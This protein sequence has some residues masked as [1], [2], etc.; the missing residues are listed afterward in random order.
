MAAVDARKLFSLWE[1]YVQ[2]TLY[3]QMST[4]GTQDAY[5]FSVQEDIEHY[6]VHQ[7]L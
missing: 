5:T 3:L 7:D 1:M 6:Y 4:G 2:I